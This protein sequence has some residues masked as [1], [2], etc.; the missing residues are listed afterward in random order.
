LSVQNRVGLQDARITQALAAIGQARD[1]VFE[2]LFIKD[3]PALWS[4]EAR[5]RAPKDLLAESRSSLGAQW[6]DS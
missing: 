1:D 3:S 4:E 2:R 6:R 5:A